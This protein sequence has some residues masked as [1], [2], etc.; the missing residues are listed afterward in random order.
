MPWITPPPP[1]APIPRIMTMSEQQDEKIKALEARIAELEKM[2]PT[3]CKPIVKECE[4]W[5]KQTKREMDPR[6]G[7]YNESFMVLECP[8]GELKMPIPPGELG[9]IIHRRGRLRLELK[10]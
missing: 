6:W 7:T 3:C 1:I 9:H 4:I 5:V 10:P 8:W 2:V